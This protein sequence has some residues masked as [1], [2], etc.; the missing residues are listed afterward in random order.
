MMVYPGLCALPPLP[1]T[2]YQL[3][4]NNTALDCYVKISLP[5]CHTYAH[6]NP[7]SLRPASKG[8]AGAR[9]AAR[10]PPSAV[11]C[12]PGSRTAQ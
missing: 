5:V 7:H 1:L 2:P 6:L 8:S 3:T 9:A 11:S 4:L 10:R 12:P